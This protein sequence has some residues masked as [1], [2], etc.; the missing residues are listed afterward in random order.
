MPIS[1]PDIYVSDKDYCIII[2]LCTKVM[3]VIYMVLKVIYIVLL[4]DLAAKSLITPLPPVSHTDPPIPT[5]AIPCL[6]CRMLFS[7]YG[8]LR[9]HVQRIHARSYRYHCPVCHKGFMDSWELKR[10]QQ[11]R[12]HSLLIETPLTE[13]KD[14]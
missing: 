1:E 5:S 2:W 11:S 14:V 12:K 3:K 9:R 4:Q 10:H 13:H 6:D 7:C 8:S